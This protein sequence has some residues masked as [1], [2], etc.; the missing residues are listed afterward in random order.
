[1][2]TL[3]RNGIGKVR[4][5]SIRDYVACNYRLD[6]GPQPR[7]EPRVEGG[8]GRVGRTGPPHPL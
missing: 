1:M 3:P 7:L 5:A 8:D 4:R 2:E 6:D